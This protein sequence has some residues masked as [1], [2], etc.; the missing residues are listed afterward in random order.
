MAGV[1]VILPI[2]GDKNER[3][4]ASIVNA[5]TETGKVLLAKLN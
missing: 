2:K 5:M 3:A 4:L 1:D